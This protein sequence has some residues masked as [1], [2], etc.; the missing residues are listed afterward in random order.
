MSADDTEH[1]TSPPLSDFD[2][3]K[4]GQP[5]DGIV[6][7]YKSAVDGRWRIIK[8]EDHALQ[9]ATNYPVG[10]LVEQEKRGVYDESESGE[11][12]A[13]YVSPAGSDETEQTVD[14]A[15]DHH[16]EA[17]DAMDALWHVDWEKQPE[18][19]DELVETAIKNLEKTIEEL[20][21][22]QA[23]TEQSETF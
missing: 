23:K 16:L 9:E 14:R 17:G 20:R 1:E 12:R 3:W 22:L 13:I 4:V 18:Y 5:D 2:P 7:L 11:L 6:W 19:G 8:D 15:Y 21:S 10:E